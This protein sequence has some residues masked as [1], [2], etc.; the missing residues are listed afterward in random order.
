M[1]TKEQIAD[2]MPSTREVLN[3]AGLDYRRPTSVL[4]FEMLSVFALGLAI[5][6]VLAVVMTSRQ[7]GEADDDGD[8]HEV[9]PTRRPGRP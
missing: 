9:R 5:G 3:R 2:Y 4:A 1:T 6:A 7:P 8:Q